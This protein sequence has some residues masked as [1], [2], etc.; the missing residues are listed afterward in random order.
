[1]EAL[2]TTQVYAAWTYGG[3]GKKCKLYQKFSK[4]EGGETDC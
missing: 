4:L 3:C 2:N 1:M